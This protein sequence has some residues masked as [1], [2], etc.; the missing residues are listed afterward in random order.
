MPDEVEFTIE[1]HSISWCYWINSAA[2]MQ[3]SQ[4][5]SF[6]ITAKII[7][8]TSLMKEIHPTFHHTATN[9]NSVWKVHKDNQ[10]YTKMANNKKFIQQ[11]KHTDLEMPSFESWVK[12]NKRAAENHTIKNQAQIYPQCNSQMNFY[13][14]YNSFTMMSKLGHL[15]ISCKSDFNDVPLANEQLSKFLAN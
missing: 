3:E 15:P 13:F 12:Q 1:Y 6:S 4:H 8:S 14:V 2:K 11:T 5:C 7:H 9:L 10:S